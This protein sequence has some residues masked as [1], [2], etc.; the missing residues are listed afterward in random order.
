MPKSVIGPQEPVTVPAVLPDRGLHLGRCLA[1]ACRFLG[2]AACLSDRRQFLGSQAE[3]PGNEDRFGHRAIHFERCRLEGFPGFLR[4]DI[5]VETVV[6]VGAT[7]ERQSV[8]TQP[9]Q[10][11]TVA[12]LQ[13]FIQWLFGARLVFVGYWLVQDA[14]V[15]GLFEVCCHAQDEPLRIIIE[16]TSHGVVAALRQGLILMVSASVL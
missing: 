5:E 2:E 9:L 6:P 16:A 7:D 15:A 1:V 14:P 12:A 11:I 8:G 10:R 3:K 13:V 4:E